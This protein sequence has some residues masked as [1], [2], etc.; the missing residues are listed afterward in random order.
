M[1][2]ARMIEH[3]ITR[4][5]L[6]RR[7][8]GSPAPI[9]NTWVERLIAVLAVAAGLSILG[10]YFEEMLWASLAIATLVTLK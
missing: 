6:E 9:C 4:Q 3:R 2:T 1:T 7:E 8:T 5:L 10:S